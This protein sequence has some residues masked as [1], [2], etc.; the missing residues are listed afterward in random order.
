MGGKIEMKFTTKV[1]LD[2]NILIYAYEQDNLV[3]CSIARKCIEEISSTNEMILS[4][5]NLAEF[6]RVAKEKLKSPLSSSEIKSH[7]KIFEKSFTII[8]YSS[9][10][11]EVAL[12]L[13]DKYGI[14]FFDALLTATMK[15]NGINTILTEN[16]KDFNKIPWLNVVNPFKRA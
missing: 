1:L 16:E 5:Q 6:S 15:E 9:S 2:T 10:S 3:K 11:I 8:Y 12:E 13:V 14:H 4:I 7:L